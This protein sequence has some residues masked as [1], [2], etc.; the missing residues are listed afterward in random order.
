MAPFMREG[1]LGVFPSALHITQRKRNARLDGSSAADYIAVM[2]F[3]AE[4]FTS[5][6]FDAVMVLVVFFFKLTMGLVLP[7]L[8]LLAARHLLRCPSKWPA[9][10]IGGA[11]LFVLFSQFFYLLLDPVA[12]RLIG[13]E[14]KV[15]DLVQWIGLLTMTGWVVGIINGVALITVSRRLAAASRTADLPTE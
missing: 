14:I 6:R 9:Y 15:E 8:S 5:S 13:V 12:Q 2:L 3:L 7:I 1:K 4:G 10:A 11:A